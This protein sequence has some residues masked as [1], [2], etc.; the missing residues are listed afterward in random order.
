MREPL[1]LTKAHD[2]LLA[3]LLL[4]ALLG[5]GY[6]LRVRSA[7]PTAPAGTT[8]A[9]SAM[10]LQLGLGQRLEALQ[11]GISKRFVTAGQELRAPWDRAAWAVDAKESGDAAL[12]DR[13]RTPLPEGE[14]GLAFAQAWS[15]AYEEGPLPAAV[16]APLKG[17]RAAAL[18]ENRLRARQ[19][20]APLPVPAPDLGR[21]ALVGGLVSLF[22]LGGLVT[23]IFL[24]VQAHK[25]WPPQ[26]VWRTGGRGAMLILSGW[27]V[28]FFVLG[29]APGLLLRGLPQG[30]LWSLPLGYA[31]QAAFGIW[32]LMQVEGL[33]FAELRARVAP[34]GR[35]GR[36]LAW[37]PAFIGLAV[38]TMFIVAMLWAPFL[39][40]HPNP[41]QE[42][43]ELIAGAKGWPVQAALF[44][45]IAGLAPCF[46]ELLFR[47]FF[48]PW[49]GERW[50][51][52]WGLA[53]SSLLFGFIHLQPWALPLL[54][55]L[56]FVLG[57]A[58]RRGGSLW[59]SIAVHACWNASIF[60]LVRGL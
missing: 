5:I 19:G 33:S 23:F 7:P 25:P 45:T 55:A 26:P 32:L 37:A 53:A 11:P 9:L 46:E 2:P 12:A 51:A 43:Q 48:L 39:K 52:G 24:L 47:G 27:L 42:M 34:R 4:L 22:L 56:G 6:T 8:R 3:I 59:T 30:R 49:A 60:L 13:L 54:A 35:G 28:G 1:K 20:L 57:L 38:L 50:G 36:A 58:A 15:A 41:Q 21:L 40:G 29:S 10:E 44:L 14:A 31:L 18:L 16:P 17:T